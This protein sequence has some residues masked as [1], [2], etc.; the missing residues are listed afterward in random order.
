MLCDIFRRLRFGPIE[1]YQYVGFG[2]VAFVDFRLFHRTLGITEMTS[3]E[4][5]APEE[6][7]RFSRN[8]P[9]E[10]I[11]LIFGKSL[12]VLPKLNFAKPTIIWLD[13]DD[14]LSKSM[15]TDL[16]SVARDIES[17]SFIGVTLP[18]GFFAEGPGRI[19]IFSK[20]KG[21]F[22]EYISD[23][24]KPSMMDGPRFAE[25]GRTV[26]GAALQKALGDSDAGKSQELQRSAI[27]ICNFRYKDGAPMATFG[28]VVV[29]EEDKSKFE[30]SK[31]DA[32]SFIRTDNKY[33]TIKIPLITP[34]EVREMERKLPNLEAEESLSWI[35]LE[36]REAFLN[37]Y[38]YLPFFAPMEA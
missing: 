6:E 22:P 34:L 30:A 20:L 10:G 17:G 29:A 35:P 12:K 3:I 4:D 37:I 36:E 33:F 38:R 9:F 32:L 8:T 26:L 31:F 14:V 15:T 21:D 28:W 27:Q 24:A 13:Y 7:D 2:S 23:D 16:S 11:N 18:V 5:A 1:A 25:F 19:K